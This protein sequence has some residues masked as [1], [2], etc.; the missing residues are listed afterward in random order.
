MHAYLR[1]VLADKL[2]AGQA[3]GVRII[4]GG[5]VTDANCGELATQEDIDGFLVGGASLK[6]PAFVSICNARAPAAARK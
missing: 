2:G 5:S 4:Y 6:A 3:E 1:R